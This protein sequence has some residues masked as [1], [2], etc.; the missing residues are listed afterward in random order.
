LT[1]F[2]V[3]DEAY[4]PSSIF[5]KPDR[6]PYSLTP[7]E[8]LQVRDRSIVVDD[9]GD[10]ATVGSARAHKK[11]GFLIIRIGDFSSETTL[12]EP[13]AKS[14]LQ[15]LRLLMP[16]EHVRLLSVRTLVELR[17]FWAANHGGTSHVVLVAHAE[18]GAVSFLD[19]GDV[20]GAQLAES[21]MEAAPAGAG[22]V[23]ASLACSSGR[24]TFAKGF[25]D[26][27]VCAVLAAPFDR[28]HGAAASQFCQTFFLRLLL[29]GETSTRAFS[30]AAKVTVGETHFRL[31]RNGTIEAGRPTRGG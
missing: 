26:S 27:P 28:I 13:L 22:K 5:A 23:W 29:R 10:F 30:A 25:S 21:L 9:D 19:A 18:N 4:V 1:K 16:D 24:S 11:V 31:W 17:E 14:V 3:G 12:L 20:A 2:A 7:R 6:R 15:F 8:V